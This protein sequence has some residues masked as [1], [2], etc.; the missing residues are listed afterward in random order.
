MIWQMFS[1]RKV[2][3]WSPFSIWREEQLCGCNVATIFASSSNKQGLFEIQKKENWTTCG[4]FHLLAVTGE[5]TG[6]SMVLSRCGQVGKGILVFAFRVVPGTERRWWWLQWWF[7]HLSTFP[8]TPLP[9]APP[10][11]RKPFS[12]TSAHVAQ[13]PCWR[14]SRDPP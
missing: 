7:Q 2:S 1:P 4:Y 11:A 8:W 12:Q 6:A 13:P 3:S 9:S 14:V 10:I 5:K